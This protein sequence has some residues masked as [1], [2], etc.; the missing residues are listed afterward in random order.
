[1]KIEHN[2]HQVGLRFTAAGPQIR[3][4]VATE[5]GRLAARVA[6]DMRRAAPKHRSTLANSVRH[7]ELGEFEHFVGPHV[8]YALWVEKGRKPGKGLPRFFDPAAASIVGWLE[9]RVEGARLK[10]N[11]KYRRA[12]LGSTRRTAAELELRDRYMAL[13]RHV[14]LHGLKAAPYVKPT[15]DAWRGRLADGLALAIRRGIR[16]AGIGRGTA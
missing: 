11:A 13:S 6:A 12:R 1:V 15:A 4:E 9:A 2:A 7:D 16:Q 8:D 14:K 5:L 3:A 10:A